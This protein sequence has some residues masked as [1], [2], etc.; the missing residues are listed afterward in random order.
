LSEQL[1]PN[2]PTKTYDLY[3]TRMQL[4]EPEFADR[5]VLLYVNGTE[6]G[7][8]IEARLLNIS[9]VDDLRRDARE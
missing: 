9:G 3:S 7:D 5:P 2:G 8:E 4:L 1:R 6:Q